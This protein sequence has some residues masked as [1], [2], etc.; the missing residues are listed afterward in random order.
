MDTKDR[1]LSDTYGHL[2]YKLNT[3]FM[4]TPYYKE[5]IWQMRNFQKIIVLAQLEH[6]SAV[7]VTVAVIDSVAC[8]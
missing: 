1:H 6:C 4:W 2:Q 7:Y 5:I 3:F 8:C